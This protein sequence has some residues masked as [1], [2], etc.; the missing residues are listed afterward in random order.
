MKAVKHQLSSMGAQATGAKSNEGEERIRE[1]W[2]RAGGEKC[3]EEP[4]EPGLSL[5]VEE[6]KGYGSRTRGV[7]SSWDVS[8]H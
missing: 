3:E 1:P 2:A 6:G 4:E 8:E 5:T 7:K